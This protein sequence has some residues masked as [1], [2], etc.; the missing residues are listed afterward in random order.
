MGKFTC[1][2]FETT[3]IEKEVEAETVEL[4]IAAANEA[5]SQGWEGCD[6]ESL[7]TDG[8]VEVLDAGGNRVWLDGEKE[9]PDGA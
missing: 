1:V 4:A 3:R 7:G 5:T 8:V 9:I 2:Y 6:E